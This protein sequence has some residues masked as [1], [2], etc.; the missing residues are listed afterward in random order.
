MEKLIKLFTNPKSFP[1][2]VE[3]PIKVIQT[4]GA[5]VF[6]T[7]KYAYKIKKPVDLGFFDYST[8]NKRK[9]N[10]DLELELNR[11]YCPE[12]YLEVL[13][14]FIDLGKDQN[15]FNP[16][17]QPF[18]YAL[19]MQQFPQS[20]LLSKQLSNDLL[21][22]EDFR[23]LGKL[24]ADCHQ[25]SK[26][27]LYI[28]GYGSIEKIRKSFDDNYLETKKFIGHL[29]T[30]KQYEGTKKF[31]DDFF[32]TKAQLLDERKKSGAIRECHGDLHLNNI[33]KWQGK[34]YLFDR[35]EFCEEFRN[36]DTMYDIA[37]TV[38]DLESNQA[39]RFAS[40][41]LNS[42]LEHSGDWRGA[43]VLPLYLSRQA[44]VRAKV[45][46]I[47]WEQTKNSVNKENLAKKARHYYQMA[48]S[49]SQPKKG[50][51]WIMCG[52]SGS[53]K[54][55]SADFLCSELGGIHIRTDAMRKH[56][57]GI[58]PDQHGEDS[59]YTNEMTE[60][61][62]QNIATLGL[63]LVSLGYRVFLDGKYDR[64]HQRS[65]L[66][67]AAQSQGFPLHIVHCEA[68]IATLKARI[69]ARSGDISDA[70]PDMIDWQAEAFEGFTHKEKPHLFSIDME[71]ESWRDTLLT[72]AQKTGTTSE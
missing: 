18:E 46:S 42:Y 72:F 64:K 34:Y 38:M 39:N 63:D 43:A 29:Q 71:G 33:S 17:G 6:L 13:P 23:V 1:H 69:K 5:V 32:S 16:T 40:I 7:G 27:D 51:L 49:Y 3:E 70:K 19:K 55:T 68:S 22:D 37:F 2:E 67:H 11:K 58:P 36:V 21:L 8:L 9:K 61:T 56:L 28:Q 53:G 52:L 14:V 26:T 54:S 24:V 66:L 4:H 45:S 41:F 48:F 25:K 15:I 47:L 35:I 44:Y 10:L 57:A 20:S 59:I 50:E 12:L 65:Q 60:K 62:Y 31:T 30:R